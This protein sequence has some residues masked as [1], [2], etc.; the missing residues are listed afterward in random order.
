MMSL[1][2]EEREAIRRAYSR[3][4]KSQR[5]IGRRRR[6]KRRDSQAGD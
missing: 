1:R 3:E 4:R 6:K 5:Q 2:E